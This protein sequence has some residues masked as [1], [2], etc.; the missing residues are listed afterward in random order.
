MEEP[1][2]LGSQI[3]MTVIR[4]IGMIVDIRLTVLDLNDNGAVIQDAVTVKIIIYAV[5]QLQ[6]SCLRNVRA[7]VLIR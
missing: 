6:I 4:I 2:R 5:T 3:P 7:T 1:C